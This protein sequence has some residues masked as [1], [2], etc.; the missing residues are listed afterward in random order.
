MVFCRAH[1]LYLEHGNKLLPILRPIYRNISNPDIE[2]LSSYGQILSV[3]IP[4][5]DTVNT[6]D[7]RPISFVNSDYKILAK[8]WDKRLGLVLSENIGHHQKGFIPS[9][10]GRTH[11]IP[12][13]PSW[14]IIK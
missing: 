1:E 14:T 11:V 6:A 13:K 5:I 12:L 10:D 2:P 4:K 8:V 7:Y 3:L 9:R